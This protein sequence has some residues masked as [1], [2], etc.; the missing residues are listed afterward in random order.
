MAVSIGIIEF[1]S[2]QYMEAVALRDLVLRKPLNLKFTSEDLAKED[3][4][5]HIGA[6]DGTRIIGILLLKPVDDERIKMRQVAVHPNH[7]GKGIGKLMVDFAEDFA[8]N[9]NYRVMELNARKVAVPFYLSQNYTTEGDE[10]TE[11]GIPH[12]KM[13]KGLER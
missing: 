13:T 8:T 1:N 11:V 12:F 10:F 2:E 5:Y 3:Q 6:T 9:L 7:Q 4:E